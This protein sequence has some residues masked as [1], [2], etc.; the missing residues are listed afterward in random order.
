MFNI[1]WIYYSISN[2]EENSRG[3]SGGGGGFES[4][5]NDRQN[6]NNDDKRKNDWICPAEGCGHNN[7]AS[8]TECQKCSEKRPEGV[9]GDVQ[10]ER[11]REFYIPPDINEAELFTNGI[12]SGINFNKFK[13]IPVKVTGRDI[14]PPCTSFADSGLDP[15]LL[16]NI[17]K[18][19]YSEPT[20]IQKTAIPIVMKGRD[21]MACAQTGSGKTAAFLL[22][23]INT[24]LT[25]NI[26]VE[27]GSPQVLIMSPTRELAIQVSNKIWHWIDFPFISIEIFSLSLYSDTPRSLQVCQGQYPESSVHLRRHSHP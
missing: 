21:L 23:I 24:L 14:P 1:S 17:K 11:P 19:S 22:P 13:D 8:R 2:V 3:G 5:S 6:G 7:F 10:T 15:F 12:S 16:A 9:G 26:P 27:P 20:P 25:D 18:S 4:R